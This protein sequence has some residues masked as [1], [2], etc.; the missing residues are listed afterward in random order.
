MTLLRILSSAAL[1]G[2]LALTLPIASA[3]EAHAQDKGG[4]PPNVLGGGGGGFSGGGGGGARMG[5]GPG[6]GGGGPAF[7]GGGGGGPAFRGG[8]GPGPRIGM[9]G[10]YHRG[11]NG[12]YRGGYHRGYG[13][14]GFYP[15]LAA[16]AILGG[17]IAGP[18]YSDPYYYDDDAPVVTLAPGGRDEAYCIRRFRS[19]DPESGTYL[20]NDGLRHPCP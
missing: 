14:G 18:Y 6:I 2:T 8:G 12:G 4:L 7:R 13:G 9:G 20:G 3:F 17:A 11:Y 19:Y 15:G 10:G 5:G 16:G 1:A